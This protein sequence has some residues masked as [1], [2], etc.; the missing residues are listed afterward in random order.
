MMDIENVRVAKLVEFKRIDKSTISKSAYYILEI[1]HER[2]STVFQLGEEYSNYK[3]AKMKIRSLPKR[4]FIKATTIEEAKDLE[5]LAI[6]KLI[7]NIPVLV[8]SKLWRVV[9]KYSVWRSSIRPST[10]FCV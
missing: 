5:R 1:P 2:T 4:Y 9:S 10:S 3:L 8:N 6:V 7:C